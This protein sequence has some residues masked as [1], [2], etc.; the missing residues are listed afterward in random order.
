M[1]EGC[2]FVL[3]SIMST[4]IN[5]PVTFFANDRLQQKSDHYVNHY[6]YTRYFFANDRLQQKSD[7]YVYPLPF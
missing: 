6:K 5:I 2:S 4:I 7:H 1:T 3:Y